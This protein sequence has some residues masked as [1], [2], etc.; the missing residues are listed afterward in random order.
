MAISPIASTAAPDWSTAANGGGREIQRNVLNRGRV[1]VEPGIT[2]NVRNATA[3]VQASGSVDAEGPLY[4]F[5]GR[6][7]FRN[8]PH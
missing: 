1:H 6:F 4:L 8:L 2:V 7:D 3:F 5:G